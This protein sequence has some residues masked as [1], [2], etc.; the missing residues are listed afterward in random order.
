MK[1]SL[2]RM[3]L[4]IGSGKVFSFDDKVRLG[5]LGYRKIKTR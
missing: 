3:K 5:E 4:N 2:N 1:I